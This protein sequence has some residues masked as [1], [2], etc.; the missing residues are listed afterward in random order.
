MHTIEIKLYRKQ[1]SKYKYLKDD[2]EWTRVLFQGY[3][4]DF[5][6]EFEQEIDENLLDRHDSCIEQ[7]EDV[8][9]PGESIAETKSDCVR[10]LYKKLAVICHPDKPMGNADTFQQ[11]TQLHKENDFIGMVVFSEALLIPLESIMQLFTNHDCHQIVLDEINNCL[12]KLSKDIESMQKS[13]AW[14]WATRSPDET[15]TIRS[16]I[17]ELISR[18]KKFEC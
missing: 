17:K 16:K 3:N 2:K 14:V 18:Q 15:E 12:D 6:R 10:M 4:E 9:S 7:T 8:P 11:L 1:I 13:L 5:K